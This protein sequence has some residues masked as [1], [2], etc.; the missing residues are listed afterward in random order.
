[1]RSHLVSSWW[2]A[3][4]SD[5]PQQSGHLRVDHFSTDHS[6]AIGCLAAIHLASQHF[7]SRLGSLCFSSTRFFSLGVIL[8]GELFCSAWFPALLFLR[9]VLLGFLS[10]RFSSLSQH[11]TSRV[12]ALI[13]ASPSMR[14]A[15]QAPTARSRGESV[16]R[17]RGWASSSFCRSGSVFVFCSYSSVLIS[18]LWL[19][20][21]ILRLR[22]WPRLHLCGPGSQKQGWS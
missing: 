9:M 22:L 5:L 18:R 1:M 10:A 20:S 17:F 15:R 21:R 2:S 11:G 8:L 4:W 14:Q 19:G 7:F 6:S 3:P 16:P 13:L 12:A